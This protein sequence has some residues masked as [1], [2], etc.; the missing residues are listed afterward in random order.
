MERSRCCPKSSGI[1]EGHCS[2]LFGMNSMQL[3]LE[4]LNQKLIVIETES[5][6][7]VFSW[8]PPPLQQ[9]ES[10]SRDGET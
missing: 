9:T 2:P 1:G 3:A 5:H 10:C 8:F 7:F 4:P 6:C